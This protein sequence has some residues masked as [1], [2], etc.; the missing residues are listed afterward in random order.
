MTIIYHDRYPEHLLT[1]GHPESPQRL[2]ET[3]EKLKQENLYKNVLTPENGSYEEI[4][5]IHTKDFFELIKYFGEGAYDINTYIREE[6]WEIALLAA[7]GTNLAGKWSYDNCK[8]AFSL[9]R[10]PGHHAGKDYAGGFCIFNNIAVA[11]KNLNCKVAIIDIDVHHGNGTSDI[12]YDDDNILYI[13]THQSG[14]FPGTGQLRD[15]GKD[16]GVGFNVNIPFCHGCGDSSFDSAF[17]QI[18]SPIV[19]QF[20][21]EMILVSIGTDGHYSDPLASLTLSSPGY[22]ELS[23]KIIELSKKICQGRIAFSLEGG[24][25]TQALA[26]VI[27]GTIASIYDR[28]ID[29]HYTKI[30]D[31]TN[32]GKE[33]IEKVLNIQSSY[34]KL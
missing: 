9:I 8:P 33:I 4:S 2:I 31:N 21:P 19:K 24:Y 34:W 25:N 12:F 13:S 7:A 27:S 28:E 23:K 30:K 5:K 22:I 6:T 14:I 10:P 29:L 1:Y 20:N 18:I 26:E 17:D 16:K 3:I 11:A 32:I 15:I